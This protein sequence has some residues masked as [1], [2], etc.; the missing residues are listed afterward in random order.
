VQL[1]YTNPKQRQGGWS[2]SSVHV[3]LEVLAI[4]RV[5]VSR[6]NSCWCVAAATID[7]VQTS[8]E[9]EAQWWRGRSGNISNLRRRWWIR[10]V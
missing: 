2:S 10:S 5:N 3:I 9:M 6:G 8:P 7:N 4:A 1:V